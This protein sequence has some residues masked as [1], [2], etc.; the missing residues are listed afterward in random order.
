MKKRGKLIKIFDL[1]LDGL[2][3]IGEGLASINIF[4]HNNPKI[5]SDEEAYK[6]DAESLRGDWDAVGG[7]LEKAMRNFES[8][9]EKEYQCP[10]YNDKPFI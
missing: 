10:Q 6:K 9:I 5:L 3:S 2:Y 4:P 7:D 1:L 8:S